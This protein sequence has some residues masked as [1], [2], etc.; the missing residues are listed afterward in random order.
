MRI[1]DFVMSVVGILI[2]LPLLM[3]T[4]VL[5]KLTS[6]GSIIFSQKRVGLNG[7]LFRL[8]KFRTM[9]VNAD[10][11]G[12]SVTTGNDTRITKV[13]RYLR[14]TKIDELPQLFNV[15]KGDMS[16]VGPR[17]EVPEIVNNY[18]CE[19]KRILEVKPGITSNASL[20]LRNEEDL[21]SLAKEPDKAY[22]DI[23]VP[24]KIELAM[25]H[26]YRKSALFDLGVLILTVWT[27]TGG[28]I[29]HFPTK[30]HHIVKKIRQEIERMNNEVGLNNENSCDERRVGG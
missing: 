5:I 30:E 1:F 6:P 28:R 2:L 8:Y 9:V 24:A 10:Q 7:H 19:M 14:K 18:S 23:F 4:A 16:F 3:F 25:E 29:V 17:P 11:I 22:E 15:L 26:V 20:F 27:L 12:T 13:G 21:L